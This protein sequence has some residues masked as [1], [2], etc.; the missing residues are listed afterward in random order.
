MVAFFRS[1]FRQPSSV[2]LDA[3]IDAR[4]KLYC[5]RLTIADIEHQWRKYCPRID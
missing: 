4:V 5:A 3:I 2:T 1:L